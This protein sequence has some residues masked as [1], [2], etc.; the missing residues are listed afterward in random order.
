LEILATNINN[1]ILFDSARISIGDYNK[2]KGNA[3]HYSA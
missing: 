2:A 3:T 1:P